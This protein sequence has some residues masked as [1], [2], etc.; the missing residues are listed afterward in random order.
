MIRADQI[1]LPS[2]ERP[3]IWPSVILSDIRTPLTIRNINKSS[4]EGR[5]EEKPKASQFFKSSQNAW[6]FS[7]N[8]EAE[9]RHS[10]SGFRR[11]SEQVLTQQLFQCISDSLSE[12]GMALEVEWRASSMLRIQALERLLQNTAPQCS[13][14]MWKDQALMIGCDTN[15]GHRVRNIV[16][17]NWSSIL[18]PVG[19]RFYSENLSVTEGVFRPGSLHLFKIL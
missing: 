18:E 12:A 19:C 10:A 3:W 6:E 7:W 13:S 1:G 4:K 8:T 15:S 2:R 11:R 9:M 16:A 14:S 17:T 5:E